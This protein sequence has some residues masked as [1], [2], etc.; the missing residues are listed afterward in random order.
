MTAHRSWLYVPGHHPE[1]V[2]KAIASQADAVVIDLEDAVPPADKDAARS[3]ALRVAESA[4]AQTLSRVW[5]RVNAFTSPWGSA[6]IDGLAQAP[7]AGLRLP[8]A[9][10]VSQVRNVAESVRLPV[11]LIVETAAGLAAAHDLASAH[12]RVVGIGL[13]ESDLSADLRVTGDAGLDWARGLIVVAARAAGRPSPVQSVW[14]NVADLDGLAR[15]SARGR[16][17]GFFGRS[18]VHPRQID[19][20]HAA[21]TPSAEDITRAREILAAAAEAESRGEVALLDAAGRFIDPAVVD[22]AR[23]TTDIADHLTAQER[24]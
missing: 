19:P 10:E 20:V 1:R 8:R 6:D 3:T 23:L 5:V 15:S 9:A 7:F 24:P 13:G 4:S 18:I 17:M 16:A 21:Y 12:D 14:T 11:Q 2:T 22:H